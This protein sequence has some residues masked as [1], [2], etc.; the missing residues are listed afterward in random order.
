MKKLLLISAIILLT[1]SLGYAGNVDTYGIGSKATA[2]GGAFS[3][4]ADDPYAIYYNPAGLTQLEKSIFSAGAYMGKLKIDVENYRV[5]DTNDPEIMGPENFSDDTSHLIIPHLGFAMPLSDRVGLGI[6][7]YAPWGMDIEWDSNPAKNPA[8]YNFYH[9]YY[10]RQ[11][12]TPAFAYKISDKFSVG[13]GV[14]IGRSETGHEGKL[15]VSPD[16]GQDPVLGPMIAESATGRA[17]EAIANVEA[18]NQAAGGV[19]PTIRTA[20]AAYNF[21]T[22]YA[23]HMSEQAAVFRGY[24]DQGLETPDQ[25]GQAQVAQYNGVPATDHGKN[26]DAQVEDKDNYS[27]NIGV[28]YKPKEIITLGLTYRSRTSTNFEGHVE[29]EG[30]RVTDAS[31][32]F[33]HPEQVQFGIRYI[34]DSKRNI[35]MEFDL[36]WTNWSINDVQYGPMTPGLPIQVT[37]GVSIVRKD[38]TC[39]RDWKDTK[40]IRFGV[41]WKATDIVTLRGGYFYDPSPIPDDTLDLEWADADK[42][43]YSLGCGLNFGNFGVDSVFQYTDIERA[44]FLGG[45]SDNMNQSYDGASG[46]RKKVSM[47]ADGHVWGLGLTFNYRF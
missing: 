13:F 23:P 22:T 2:L 29:K 5:S 11:V 12:V 32:E 44:R 16:L 19:V 34:P 27:F 33:D 43:T 35:S 21:L 7:L 25:I 24:A 45:E 26:V 37:D 36:V 18:V 46:I 38:L 17:N 4:Y 39:R 47:N 15:Y 28:M 1:G 20:T 3:A 31:L 14:S 6:A 30:G 8:A 40:Q 41:E 9:S 42:K 10:S